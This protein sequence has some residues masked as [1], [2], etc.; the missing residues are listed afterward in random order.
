MNKFLEEDFSIV[1]NKKKYKSNN[2][3]EIKLQTKKK[4][5]NKNIYNKKFVRKIT[6]I[7]NK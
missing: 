5:K 6:S 1:N 4:N 7:K 3:R 2:N